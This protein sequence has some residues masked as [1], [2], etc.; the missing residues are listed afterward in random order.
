MAKVLGDVIDESRWVRGM[1]SRTFYSDRFERGTVEMKVVVRKM[2]GELE[3]LSEM[4]GQGERKELLYPCIG[5]GTW[6]IS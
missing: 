6:K 3:N 4:N 1:Y 2:N 5:R